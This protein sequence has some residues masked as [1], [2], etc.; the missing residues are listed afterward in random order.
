MLFFPLFSQYLYLCLYL[1]LYLHLYFHFNKQI[2]NLLAAMLFFPLFSQYLSSFFSG[3][4]NV[5]KMHTYICGVFRLCIFL[6]WASAKGVESLADVWFRYCKGVWSSDR[7][8]R[9]QGYIF[10]PPPPSPKQNFGTSFLPYPKNYPLFYERLSFTLERFL[11]VGCGLSSS[12]EKTR[13]FCNEKSHKREKR[14][15]FVTYQRRDCMLR[16]WTLGSKSMPGMEARA[17]SDSRAWKMSDYLQNSKTGWRYTMSKILILINR[18]SRILI[19]IRNQNSQ[20]KLFQETTLMLSAPDF[21]TFM[22]VC[23]QIFPPCCSD[24]CNFFSGLNQNI[25]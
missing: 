19:L 15:G 9:K 5:C 25:V 17:S 23:S 20:K 12:G 3:G 1:Y 4:V 21:I 22:F 11:M 7:I 16:R 8:I 6:V 13:F 18:L 2:K 10:T 24:L 14:I